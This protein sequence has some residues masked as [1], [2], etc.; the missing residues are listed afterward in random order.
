MLNFGFLY[1][2]IR[3]TLQSLVQDMFEWNEVARWW[4]IASADERRAP[5]STDEAQLSVR[6]NGPDQ[7]E[8]SVKKNHENSWV[9]TFSREKL[10][11]QSRS[12]SKGEYEWFYRQPQSRLTRIRGRLATNWV[13]ILLEV[14]SR[15]LHR[16]KSDPPPDRTID[17]HRH[18]DGGNGSL[19]SR[20]SNPPLRLQLLALTALTARHSFDFG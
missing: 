18:E 16:R 11:L 12:R 1:F 19:R 17:W 13:W 9:H 7:E 10:L 3:R 4:E 14:E 20:R 6:I 15:G 8:R 5:Y 2:Q